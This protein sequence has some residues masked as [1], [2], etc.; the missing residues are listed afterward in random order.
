[1]NPLRVFIVAEDLLVRVGWHALLSQQ[2]NFDLVG[3]GDSNRLI[4]DIDIY[5]PDVVVW[6]VGWQLP[7]ALNELDDT[8]LLILFSEPEQSQ[9]LIALLSAKKRAFALLPRDAKPEQ[10]NATLNAIQQGVMVFSPSV[11]EALNLPT[12]ALE[13]PT[14]TLT[15][16]ETEVLQLLAQG[17]TNKAIAHALNIT[18]HTVKFHVNAI[19]TKL[20]AQSRTDAVVKATRF[21]YV[22]L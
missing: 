12:F 11:L 19:M 17:L 2:T 7:T 13:R 20:N 4:N 3:Q 22:S 14:E 5:R 10:L 1:M 6:D 15:T 9:D 16:R 18:D 21:G 8:P